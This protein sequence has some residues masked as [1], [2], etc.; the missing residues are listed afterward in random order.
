MTNKFV[1]DANSLYNDTIRRR[2]NKYYDNEPVSYARIGT[3]L[4]ITEQTLKEFAEG[5]DLLNV[6]VG[7]LSRFLNGRGY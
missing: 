6:F 1:R 4:G 3:M 7:K 5:A 2:F